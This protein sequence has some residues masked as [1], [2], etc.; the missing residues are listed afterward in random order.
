MHAEVEDN[1]D[2]FTF[3]LETWSLWLL[4]TLVTELGSD[5]VYFK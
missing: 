1:L 5:H 4:H 2:L 3:L